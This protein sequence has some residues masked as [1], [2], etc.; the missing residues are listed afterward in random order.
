MF[1]IPKKDY[2][3]IISDIQN[4]D[5]VTVDMKKYSEQQF[6]PKFINTAIDVD[7]LPEATKITLINNPYILSNDFKDKLGEYLS[8]YQLLEYSSPYI[9]TKKYSYGVENF[10]DLPSSSNPYEVLEHSRK[11]IQS[12]FDDPHI[13]ASIYTDITERFLSDDISKQETLTAGNLKTILFKNIFKKNLPSDMLDKIYQDENVSDIWKSIITKSSPNYSKEKEIYANKA[14]RD[15]LFEKPV[16]FGEES[17]LKITQTISLEPETFSTIIN[18][19]VMGEKA[20]EKNWM[21]AALSSNNIPETIIQEIKEKTKD[22]SVRLMADIALSLNKSENS[23]DRKF[24]VN[25][26]NRIFNYRSVFA[27]AYRRNSEKEL[28]KIIYDIINK[29][30]QSEKEKPKKNYPYLGYLQQK[31][32]RM[33]EVYKFDIE[34]SEEEQ[35]LNIRP[36][37]QKSSESLK[38]QIHTLI[39]ET[40][41]N[42]ENK[43]ELFSQ[44]DKLKRD[45]HSLIDNTKIN[46]NIAER[47]RLKAM[48][49]IKKAEIKDE[50]PS[51]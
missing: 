49:E 17:L 4:G 23:N 18:K 40:E 13:S 7:A 47:D 45:I 20:S 34:L 10:F 9:T 38:S 26:A 44:L 43:L 11:L 30:L 27:F 8:Q 24:A 31:K 33:A 32:E 6:N 28:S 50:E 12:T 29:T 15:Y 39:D 22:S 37:M 16:N 5:V 46:L 25:F 3:K 2:D 14:I 19:K 21:C 51:L 41:F 48:E 42:T 1:Y 35:L 36:E